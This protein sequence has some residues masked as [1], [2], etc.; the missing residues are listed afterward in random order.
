[1]TSA[2][3]TMTSTF[4]MRDSF[5]MTEDIAMFYFYNANASYTFTRCLVFSLRMNKKY[6]LRSHILH[7][8]LILELSKEIIGNKYKYDVE[9]ENVF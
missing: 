3:F 9:H 1:M 5:C 7:M 4:D 8:N 2:V 6:I